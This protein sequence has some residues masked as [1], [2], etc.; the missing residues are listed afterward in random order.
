MDIRT[1][2]IYHVYYQGNNRQPIF[3]QERNYVYF[4]DKIRTHLLI[5]ID[6]LAYCLI[7]CPT[8]FID[9]FYTEMFGATRVFSKL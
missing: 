8:N 9:D 7:L 5:H 4:L 3:L 2:G 1:Q 6:M